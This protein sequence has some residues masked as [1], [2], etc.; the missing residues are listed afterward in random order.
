MTDNVKHPAHYA[1]D[2]PIHPACG[3]PVEPIIFT[4]AYNFN[5][6]NVLKYVLR[7]GKKGDAAQEVEDL[8]K[9]RQYLDFELDRLAYEAARKADETKRPSYPFFVWVTEDE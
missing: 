6:G 1:A 7:A 4:Q 3:E 8:K 9:A 5:R 2:A